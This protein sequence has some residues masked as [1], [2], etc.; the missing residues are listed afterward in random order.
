MGLWTQIRPIRQQESFS[1]NYLRGNHYKFGRSAS[2]EECSGFDAEIYKSE[3][4]L[5][6]LYQFSPGLWTRATI[7]I[8]ARELPLFRREITTHP[9]IFYINGRQ[10]HIGSSFEGVFWL[11]CIRQAVGSRK[12]WLRKNAG[13]WLR[14]LIIEKKKGGLLFGS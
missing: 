2:V 11:R 13:L 3:E 9:T 1:R 4:T 10:Q 8:E 14:P 12:L 6:N 7:E 5:A